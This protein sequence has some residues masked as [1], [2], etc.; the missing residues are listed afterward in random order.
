MDISKRKFYRTT[1]EVVALSEDPITD[2][3]IEDIV[4]GGVYGDYSI[5]C[6][7]ANEEVIDGVTAASA[8]AQQGSSPEFFGLNDD[9]SDCEGDEDD[10]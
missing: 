3:S 5:T 2:V 10:G 1:F 9:G 7:V 6:D 4:R 8:L